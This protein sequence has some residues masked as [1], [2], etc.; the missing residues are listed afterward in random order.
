MIAVVHNTL[1]KNGAAGVALPE[2]GR[3]G[4]V[5]IVNNAI[6]GRAGAAALP[7]PRPGADVM[8][9]VDC[10][11]GPCFADPD[12]MDFSPVLDSLLFSAGGAR[13][14]SWVPVDDYFAVPR[15]PQP[16]IGAVERRAGPVRLIPGS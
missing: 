13:R 7:K 11:W 8:G 10:R 12:A 2:G 4:D 3:L 1:Y 9:N 15:G 16:T 14:E 6:H 5:A